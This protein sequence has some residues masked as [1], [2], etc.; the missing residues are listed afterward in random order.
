MA[1]T[2]TKSRGARKGAIAQGARRRLRRPLGSRL[3]Y[4]ISTVGNR[5]HT[6]L[7]IPIA[8]RKIRHRPVKR[9]LGS[10]DSQERPPD[11]LPLVASGLRSR[12]LPATTRGRAAVSEPADS[13]RVVTPRVPWACASRALRL[14]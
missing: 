12:V 4:P 5:R 6:R 2:D 10:T 11:P 8:R 13:P 14:A 1:E 3:E 9:R 7:A